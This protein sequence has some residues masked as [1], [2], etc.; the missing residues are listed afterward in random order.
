[1]PAP[2]QE[3]IDKWQLATEKG[4]THHILMPNTPY[5]HIDTIFTHIISSIKK[6]N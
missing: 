2:E 4:I 1:M 6:L 3:L 5:K